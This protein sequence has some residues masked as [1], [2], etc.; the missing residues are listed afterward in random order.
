M[1]QTC[2]KCSRTNPRDAVY[3]YYDGM[4]LNGHG[5]AGGPVAVGLQAFASPFVFPSGKACRNF[6]ELAVA[7]QDHWS[8]ARDVLRQGFLASFFR[9]LG[10]RDPA[11]A[12][13]Q[14][15]AVPRA[16]PRPRRVLRPPP[17]HRPPPAK[18]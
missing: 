15:A 5:R 1:A 9:G 16:A 12:P 14:A 6:N 4:V 18:L 10:R 13:K 7:C 3:C 17:P 2:T 11:Q 8:A